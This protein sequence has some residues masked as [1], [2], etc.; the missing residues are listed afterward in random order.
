M[1]LAQTPVPK[2]K[3]FDAIIKAYDARD[4]D[5]VKLAFPQFQKAYPNDP[6]TKF[7]HAYINDRSGADVEAALREYSEV[8]RLAPD[9]SDPYVYRSIIFS[10]KGIDEK[11]KADITKAIELE[12]NNAPAYF[13]GLRGDYNN[14]TKDYVAAISDFKKAISISPWI[15]K[16]Y[17]G[18]MNV[19]LKAG[20]TDEALSVLAVTLSGEQSENAEIKF[21]YGELLMRLKR[22]PEADKV[23]IEALAIKNYQPSAE[24]YNSASI[25]ALNVKDMQRATRLSEEACT[26]SPKNVDIINNR[27]TIAVK[28]QLWDE[29]YTWAEKALAINSNSSLANMLM[30]IAVKR[31]GKGDALSAEYEAKAKRLEAAGN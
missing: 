21:V 25:A 30:A 17:R 19:S 24:E 14:Y 29:A 12:G 13:Y 6:F 2:G 27:A 22:M 9:L 3:A 20:T 16:Y 5:A 28:Q 26:R 1:L 23:F 18:L 11:A 4:L 8:I 15:A 31:T 10:K 7:F